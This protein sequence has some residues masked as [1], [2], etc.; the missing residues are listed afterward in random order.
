MTRL[1]QNWQIWRGEEGQGR[2]R[3]L[4][5]TV[6]SRQLRIDTKHG[7]KSQDLKEALKMVPEIWP[8]IKSILTDQRHLPINTNMDARLLHGSGQQTNKQ[9]INQGYKHGCKQSLVF[10]VQGSNYRLTQTWMQDLKINVVE[11]KGS[12][13]FRL[14][15]F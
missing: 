11:S 6:R 12:R 15:K 9:S 3:D 1:E 10:E 8:H 7:C 4:Q 13:S 5:L 2:R 14:K